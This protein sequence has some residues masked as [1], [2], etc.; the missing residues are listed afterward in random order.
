MNI[1]GIQQ[2]TSSLT[3]GQSNQDS[4]EMGIQKQIL[5]LQEKMR[6]ITYDK[7]MSAEEKSDEKKALQE[8]IQNL[9]NELKQYQLQKRQEEAQKR[10][11]EAARQ[12]ES[13]ER[14]AA[15]NTE[16]SAAKSSAGAADEQSAGNAAAVF[17]G[18]QAD[19]PESGFNNTASTTMFSS[20][21]AKEHLAQMQKIRTNLEG[22]MRTASTDEQKTKLQKRINNAAKTIGEKIRKITDAI[23]DTRKDDKA[24]KEKVQKQ[25]E[26]YREK[27]K[28][29]NAAV[30][31]TSGVSGKGKYWKDDSAMPGKVLITRKKS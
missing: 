17:A 2:T 30:P 3:A 5:T 24:R 23:A 19:E 18:K 8:K 26:E 1:T 11:E 22:Q 28:N 25:L 29:V 9:N 20:A 21:S 27:T 6:G 14:T 31:K 16:T 4:H 10:Q 13:E 7:E 15:E 12:K